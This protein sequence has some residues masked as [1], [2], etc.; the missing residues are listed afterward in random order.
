MS[1]ENEVDVDDVGEVPAVSTGQQAGYSS[2]SSPPAPKPAKVTVTLQRGDT[3]ATIAKEYLG[4]AA[5]ARDVVAQ[6][7]GLAWKPGSKITIP[8]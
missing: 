2:M 8:D 6:N 4:S 3:P 5:R 1:D 7:R